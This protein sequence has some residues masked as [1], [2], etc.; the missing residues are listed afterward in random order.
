MAKTN[1]RSAHSDLAAIWI[2]RYAR[3]LRR[4]PVGSFPFTCSGSRFQKKALRRRRLRRRRTRVCRIV[5]FTRPE[6]QL[7]FVGDLWPEF[8]ENV[9]AHIAGYPEANPS[10]SRPE[11][12][13]TIRMVE[14][15]H[16]LGANDA[17]PLRKV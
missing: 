4:R 10:G 11:A 8:T 2:S 6:G 16:S 1:R 7:E 14:V 5:F 9:P 15:G 17:K 13:G 3:D 12:T